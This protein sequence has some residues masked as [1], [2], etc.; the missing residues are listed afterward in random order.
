MPRDVVVAEDGAYIVSDTGN[1]RILRC[2]G[3][4]PA[5]EVVA[6]TGTAGDGADQ[7]H[8]PQGI[9]LSTEGSHLV[10]DTFNHRVQRCIADSGFSTCQTVA[11][12]GSYGHGTTELSGSR[13]VAINSAGE[14]VIVDTNNHRV[15]LC[16]RNSPGSVCETV[17]GTGVR[18]GGANQLRDPEDV[19]IEA[20]GDFVV[21]D[22]AN[23]RVQRC[24]AAS[25]G[26]EFETLA[27]SGVHG[28]DNSL[29]SPGVTLNSNG[30][31]LVGDS[32]NH[33]IVRCFVVGGND[34]V[35]VAGLDLYSPSAVAVLEVTTTV[36]TTTSTSRTTTRPHQNTTAAAVA[37]VSR[38]GW[39][40]PRHILHTILTVVLCSLAE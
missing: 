6:G 18:G 13:A 37:L 7:L 8:T 32:G 10:A 36:Q 3:P 4:E 27:S 40:S 33:R 23:Q 22:R 1:H 12:T 19:A 28:D 16:S 2:A 29:N 24:P 9:A 31:L 17:V 15:Q 39:P 26:A 38:G 30:D 11:G 20:N 35:L 5:C 25:P 14:L 34:V 21:A